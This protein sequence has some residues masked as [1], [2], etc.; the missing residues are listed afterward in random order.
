M[1]DLAAYTNANPDVTVAITCT[2][3]GP[4]DG[5][6]VFIDGGGLDGTVMVLR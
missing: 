6:F 3:P 5:T 2:D 1:L 4:R